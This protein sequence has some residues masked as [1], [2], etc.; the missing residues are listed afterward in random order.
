MVKVP[1]GTDFGSKLRLVGEGIVQHGVKGN[2]YITLICV[3]P[4]NPSED[5]LNKIRE[6]AILEDKLENENV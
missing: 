3:V 4:K 2:L 6:L 5:Y 1:A